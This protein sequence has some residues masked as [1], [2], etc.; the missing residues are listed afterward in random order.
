MMTVAFYTDEFT[1]V[2]LQGQSGGIPQSRGSN[3]VMTVACYADEFTNVVLMQRGCGFSVREAEIQKVCSY[4][5]ILENRPEEEFL[6]LHY[7]NGL[8]AEKTQKFSLG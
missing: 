1:K 6:V 8:G 5:E 2:V 3:N 4:E 7:I